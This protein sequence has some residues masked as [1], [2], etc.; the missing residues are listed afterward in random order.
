MITIDPSVLIGYYD[1]KAGI[2][3]NSSSSSSTSGSNTSTSTTAAAPAAPW[4]ASSAKAEPSALAQAALNGANVINPNAALTDVKGA[5]QQYKSLFTLYQGLNAL[6]GLT[7]QMLANTS[8]LTSNAQAIKAFNTGL[9]QVTDYVNGLSLPNIR[10]TNGTV[11]STASTTLAPATQKTSYTTGTIFSG[12]LNDPVP[13]FQGDVQFNIN[14]TGFNGKKTTV[15]I[16]LSGMG[17][18]DRTMPNV[19]NY[20]NDQLKAAG[21]VTRFATNSV[22]PAASTIKVNGQTVTLPAAPTNWSFKVVG[23]SEETVSF[24]APSTAAAVYVAQTS[25][26][27]L[28][29]TTT[30]TTNGKT[31]STTVGDTLAAKDAVPVQQLVKLQAT[32]ST[33]ATPPPAA[34]VVPGV[35]GSSVD[36]ANA[37]T[38]GPQ[39][40]AVHATATGPDGSIYEVADVTGSIDGQ[41]IQGSQDVALLKYDS[42]GNFVSA[43]TLGASGA[44]TGYSIAVS[45]TGAVAVAGSTTGTL[46]ASSSTLNSGTSQ[47]FVSV[48][49]SSGDLQW[50]QQA[51]AVSANQANA[52]AFGSDGSVYVV[53]Q[54]SGSLPGGTSSGGQDSYLQGYSST[55][56][57]LFTQQFGTSGT[58]AATS[59]AVDGSTLVVGGVE[60]GDA[61]VR[62]FT[63]NATGAP[64]AGTTRDLGSLQGGS[65]AGVAISNG[66]VIVA[67]T[68]SNGAL[69]AGTT[70]SAFS[71]NQDA[72][73]AQLSENLAPS[74]SDAVAYYGGTGFTK[75]T[76]LS[77]VNGQV[78]IAGSS[79]G[80][81]PNLA[82][83]NNPSKGA[84]GTTEGFV[85][86]IDVAS[87]AVQWSQALQGQDGYDAPESIAVDPTGAS[88][89]DRLGLPDG[90]LQYTSSQLLTSATS[91]RVGDQ[92]QIKSSNGG[93]AGT[94]TI[95]ADDTPSTLA[96]KI[97]QASG[98]QVTVAV[99]P[100]NGKEEVQITP[101]NPQQTFQ[102]IPGPAGKDAL[103]PLGLTA[104]LVQTG[105]AIVTPPKVIPGVT[106]TTTA[107]K[108]IPT[109]AYG[110][111]LDQSF[112]LTTTAG[113]KAAQTA[114]QAAMA[115]VQNA[116]YNLSTA[117]NPPA[118]AVTGTVPAYLT[119]QI[120]N[121]QSA[122]E[123][124]TGSSSTSS[125]SSS[126]SSAISP[127]SLALQ[128]LG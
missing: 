98:Y 117:T 92:F 6:D 68:T 32:N 101:S 64:T 89:L 52:V 123:R 96:Q 76:A 102:L 5:S 84:A 47:S 56:T 37:T 121:Y 20:I 120:A 93:A 74:S 72:F 26:D 94:V 21:L 97:R 44:A 14:V 111:N 105:P 82:S 95:S 66:Q 125:S 127:S 113:I 71:G 53:G 73:V 91:V 62:S 28:G 3:E 12:G 49:D 30:T 29:G 38:L 48:F 42:A 24:S 34:S 58:D 80:G 69:S 51:S 61:V 39:V 1:S 10:L 23:D 40:N 115:K 54:T 104:G 107:S 4:N 81:L 18:T 67:G 128:I 126:S 22:T 50:S 99:T 11:S 78:Y 35:S 27:P 83:P 15:P 7:T 106:S 57:K 100:V 17:S 103:A 87:G 8:G 75:A 79:S 109:D 43:T 86:N 77:V 13:A 36:E 59:V 116:Y 88:V 2:L 33:T 112:D 90:T 85:A 55:G 65:V 63:L 60:S 110:L 41:T 108:K 118:P 70:T 9:G 25:G 114:I 46:E 119:A 45:S 19:V 122:L 31:T 16:D 124:L